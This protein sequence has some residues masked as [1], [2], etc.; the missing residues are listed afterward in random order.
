MADNGMKDGWSKAAQRRA[1]RKYKRPTR[2]QHPLA[3]ETV[4]TGDGYTVYTDDTG[5]TYQIFDR[6]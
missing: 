3:T 6:S 5:N 4:A 2:G 1:A